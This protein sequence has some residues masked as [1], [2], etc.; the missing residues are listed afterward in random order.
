MNYK[1]RLLGGLI[2]FLSLLSL[3][4]TASAQITLNVK[5]KPL[6]EVVKQI[7][8]TSEYRFFYNDDINGLG[9]LVTL[10]VKNASITT[11]MN[12]ISAQTSV[13]YLLKGKYQIILSNAKSDAA[14]TSVKGIVVDEKGEPVIGAS[15]RLKGTSGGTDRKSV[16]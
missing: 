10:N 6:R 7:E 11:V 8:S 5:G 4:M 3:S 16:V 12:Q 9:R 1:K 13:S 2:L 14:K 15:I